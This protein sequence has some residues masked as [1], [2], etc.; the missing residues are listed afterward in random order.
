[1]E[2]RIQ[3]NGKSVWENLIEKNLNVPSF[4]G[5]R[6]SCGK[7]KILVTEGILPMTAEDKNIL[8][9]Q[10]LKEGYRL[11]CRAYP[12][13][14]ITIRTIFSQEAEMAG[15]IIDLETNI[16]EERKEQDIGP[17]IA[18]DLGTTT[19]AMALLWQ[20][21]VMATYLGINHQRKIGTDV[22]T[23][24]EKAAKGMAEELTEIIRKDIWD[25][26]SELTKKSG[27]AK[28]EIEDVILAGNTVMEH[29]FFSYPTKGMES[30][31]FIPFFS[32]KTEILSEKVFSEWRGK[33]KIIGFPCISAF[34]GGDIISGLYQIEA[35]RSSKIQFFLDLGTNGEMAV[36][37]HGKIYTASVAA[38]PVFEGGNISCGIGSIPGAIFSVELEEEEFFYKTIKGQEPVG[39]CGTGLIE[40]V[41]AFLEMGILKADGSL[42]G[43][44]KE[45]GVVLA[46]NK[47]GGFIS[48][49]QSDIREFQ[50][51][52][53][54]VLAGIFILLKK[55]G[56]SVDE[57]E[58]WKIAGSFGEN[59]NI[60][61]AVKAGI[62]PKEAEK[63]AKAVGNT[64]LAGVI[65]YSFEEKQ[66]RK[67]RLKVI[68][69]GCIS[70]SLA[71]EEE[72][73]KEFLK[74][75][76]F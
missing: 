53:G 51:A 74:R 69:K 49:N 21:R 18:I 60:K 33:T 9:E 5:G 52:K 61:K 75:L 70:I 66:K 28:E 17:Q 42:T 68:K 36:C 4:C 40:A 67:E 19:L 46:R 25:G 72:F 58:E 20:N 34:I 50:L 44:Y 63:K 15:S 62:L 23:R 43:S 35:D 39:I 48:V 14:E 41:A 65:K 54:A 12:E 73:Q 32:D 3:K 59:L 16:E 22:I 29:L 6:G 38:G 26:I 13:T 7:C 71:E 30:Y 31:P 47:T 64:S 11:A 55:A 27:I 10:E 45:R 1:M 24:M 57:I 56:L 76:E 8:S 2:F 37:S